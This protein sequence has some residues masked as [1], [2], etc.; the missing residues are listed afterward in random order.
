ML[1]I[2]IQMKS[3]SDFIHHLITCSTDSGLKIKHLCSFHTQ[4]NKL[5]NYYVTYFR[6]TKEYN[7]PT[8]HPG[9]YE[10]RTE[11]SFESWPVISFHCISVCVFLF[12]TFNLFKANVSPQ[13]WLNRLKLIVLP[14]PGSL[15]VVAHADMKLDRKYFGEDGPAYAPSIWVT[16]ECSRKMWNKFQVKLPW[17]WFTV[18]RATGC[19]WQHVY[20]SDWL[21]WSDIWIFCFANVDYVFNGKPR[22]D[23]FMFWLCVTREVKLTPRRYCTLEDL[24]WCISGCMGGHSLLSYIE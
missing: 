11:Y 6:L 20:S 14:A 22:A 21:F 15:L 23:M 24:C 9:T 12:F 18:W 19:S 4:Y 5:V 17:C 3:F 10:I 13:T 2:V 16:E 1:N 8:F 7:P